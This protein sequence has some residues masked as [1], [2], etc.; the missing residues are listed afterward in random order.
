M[1]ILHIVPGLNDPTNGIAVA[2]KWIAAEQLKSKHEVELVETRD[3]ISS[4]VQPSTSNLQPLSAYAEIWVHSMWLPLTLKACWKVLRQKR[5]NLHSTTTTFNY[6]SSP[7]L[8][9][10]PHGCLDPVKV[11]YHLWKKFF[12]IPAERW[13]MRHATRIV[14]TE[15]AE[16]EWIRRFVRCGAKGTTGPAVEML[17]LGSVM[18]FVPRVGLCNRKFLFVG[19]MHPLKGVDVLIE[20]VRSLKTDGRLPDDFHLTIIGKDEKG[21]RVGFQSAAQGLPITFLG[22]VE[23]AVKH[24]EMATADCLILPT[25]SENFGLVV[26][27]SLELGVPVIT[28]DGAKYW[29]GKPG[30]N[31]LDGYVAA[32]PQMRIGMLARA[33]SDVI[34]HT[35][36]ECKQNE[37]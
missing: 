27:E 33:L 25:L 31:Y 30:V 1:K 24:H 37:G 36:I 10:M 14:A 4:S 17:E 19:R 9:R 23:E 22:E 7:R 32:T 15:E 35:G 20:A 16:A 6:N 5:E 29:R 13:L 11:R 8:V 12:F 34:K 18:K 28:T 3:F 26:K 2:A 21:M